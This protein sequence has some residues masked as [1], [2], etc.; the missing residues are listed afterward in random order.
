MINYCTFIN[1]KEKKDEKS[2][3][4][5]TVVSRYFSGCKAGI[6][7]SSQLQPTSAKDEFN[8]LPPAYETEPATTQFLNYFRRDDSLFFQE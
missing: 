7:D 4:F 8:S 5:I 1:K 6:V 2:Y 3:F